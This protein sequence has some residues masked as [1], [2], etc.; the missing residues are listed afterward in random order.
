MNYRSGLFWIIVLVILS[1]FIAYGLGQYIPVYDGFIV[2][3]GSMEPEIETGS[4][5]FTRPVAAER[6]IVGDTIT[7]QEDGEYTTHKVIRKN[8]TDEGITF[9]TQ[10]VNNEAPDPGTVTAGELTGVKLFSIPFLGYATAWAGTT[11]GFM[12][13]IIVPGVLLILIEIKEVYSQIKAS[14]EA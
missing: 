3:S 9:V 10:G 12:A 5:L 14:E 2:T 13:L 6:V 7:F 4:L 8:N 1:P 11:N